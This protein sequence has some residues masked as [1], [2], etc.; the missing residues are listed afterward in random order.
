MSWKDPRP[1]KG[2]GR[3]QAIRAKGINRIYT[4]CL[5]HGEYLYTPEKASRD[6]MSYCNSRWAG[7]GVLKPPCPRSNGDRVAG[8][9]DVH[10]SGN[11]CTLPPPIPLDFAQLKQHEPIRMQL[12]ALRIV[13]C[14]SPE[15]SQGKAARGMRFRPTP[16]STLD[17]HS[18]ENFTIPW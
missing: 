8:V 14:C 7:Y 18:L 16:Q 2:R 6:S 3:D 1:K 10:W 9:K 4:R 13:A 12:V 5:P 17:S 15:V 11:A